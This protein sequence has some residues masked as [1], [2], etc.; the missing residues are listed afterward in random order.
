MLR[1]LN[2]CFLCVRQMCYRYTKHTKRG[3]QDLNLYVFRHSFSRRASYRVAQNPQ[4]PLEGIE[5]SN[6]FGKL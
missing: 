3:L 6:P 1:E 4:T 5:P 2:S